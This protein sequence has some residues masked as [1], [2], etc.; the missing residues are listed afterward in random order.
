MAH[1]DPNFREVIILGA[2]PAG[3]S[4]AVQLIR[5]QI[6]VLVLSQNVG[7]LVHNA[8]W[9]ENLLGFPKGI[10][11]EHFVQ[12]MQHTLDRF[13]IPIVHTKIIKVSK[14]MEYNFQINTSTSIYY[15]RHLIIAT[16]TIP[17]H[18]NIP[19]EHNL[20]KGGKLYYEKFQLYHDWAP[21]KE[22]RAQIFGQLKIGI[23]GS[24]DAAYDYAI[25]LSQYFRDVYILQRHA[26]S[27]ALPLLQNRVNKTEK[28]HII[29]NIIVSQIKLVEEQ[30]VLDPHSTTSAILPR[31]DLILVAI[32]RSANTSFLS[33]DLMNGIPPEWDRHLW[34]VGDVKNLLFRQISIAMGDGVRTAM[35]ILQI[36]TSEEQS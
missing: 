23:I 19:G 28:I 5:S 6:D 13:H 34:S 15:A 10:S 12:I 9:I 36:L 26:K 2:G 7:G 35:Q 24:G 4:A 20:H 17:N 33:E 29:P 8:S 27:K 30:V 22:K 32:G 31:F 25:D 3:I 18:L 11:G 1:F 14:H 16:G 21:N